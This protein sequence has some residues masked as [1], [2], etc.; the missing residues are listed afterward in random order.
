MTSRKTKGK[1]KMENDLNVIDEKLLDPTLEL[2]ERAALMGRRITLDQIARA[3]AP[4][5]EPLTGFSVVVPPNMGLSD[6][7]DGNGRQYKVR[8]D[9]D[10]R[11]VVDITP[12]VFKILLMGSSG[13][14]WER[15]NADTD[16]WRRM[17]PG[18]HY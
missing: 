3:P 17:D 18:L 5:A 4:R 14:D 6:I 12:G 7:V 2:E 8:V 9:D 11:V 15:A 13:L 16:V 1:L 10:G